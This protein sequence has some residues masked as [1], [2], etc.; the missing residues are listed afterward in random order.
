MLNIV[1]TYDDNYKYYKDFKYI[2]E[3]IGILWTLELNTFGISL[4]ILDNSVRFWG[5]GNDLLQSFYLDEIENQSLL[6]IIKE[7]LNI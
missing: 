5:Y 6:D 1:K 7:Q 3:Y 2:L 4:S